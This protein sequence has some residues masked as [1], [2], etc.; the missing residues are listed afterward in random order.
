MPLCIWPEDI[1]YIQYTTIFIQWF[2]LLLWLQNNPYLFPRFNSY[3]H[4]KITG[5]R[6]PSHNQF[7][8]L[9]TAFYLFSWLASFGC[10]NANFHRCN[11]FIVWQ[12]H[13]LHFQ[14]MLTIGIWWLLVWSTA[15]CVFLVYLSCTQS[16]LILL[17]M[18]N[19]WQTPR[20]MSRPA[21]WKILW[22]TYAKQGWQIFSAIFWLAFR[23][24]S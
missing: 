8:K 7:Q 15:F 12:L 3:G 5:F 14:E 11:Y 18:L 1:E 13:T 19:A 6:G 24:S 4:L 10:F 21:M 23:C 2:L 17:Y 9:A 22:S 20:N 16:C